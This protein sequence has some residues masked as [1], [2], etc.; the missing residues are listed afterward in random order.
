MLPQ[1]AHQPGPPGRVTVWGRPWHGLV[2][3]GTLTLPN[4]A[5][6]AHPYPGDAGDA[7]VLA[8]RLP[9]TP[10]VVRS[11]EQAAA[12]AAA[13]RQW[14]DYALISGRYDRQL[15]GQRIGGN[16]TWLFA[17]PDGSRWLAT[18][19]GVPD[20]HDLTMPWATHL[21]LDRFGEI[22]GAAEQHTVAVTLT[23]WQQEL[24]GVG[25]TLT[26]AGS[27]TSADV[28]VED[29][30]TGGGR[31]I[32]SI[33]LDTSDA[34]DR[35]PLGFILLSLSGLPGVDATANM[36]VL[37]SRVETLGTITWDE[38][39]TTSDRMK[40]QPGS[41]VTLDEDT[42]GLPTCDGYRLTVTEAAPG[43]FEPTDPFFEP[44]YRE[45]DRSATWAFSDRIIGMAFSATGDPVALLLS[46]QTTMTEYVP[47]P[48][49]FASGGSVSSM[50]EYLGPFQD[51]S[52]CFISPPV[53]TGSLWSVLRRIS[54]YAAT[55]T[56]SLTFGSGDA[57]TIALS[58]TRHQEE[59]FHYGPDAPSHDDTR[60]DTFSL[61]GTAHAVTGLGVTGLVAEGPLLGFVAYSEPADAFAADMKA[62]PGVGCD[63]TGFWNAVVVRYSAT[64]AELATYHT[65]GDGWQ[66]W[67]GV[68]PQRTD[69]APS[70]GH[71]P[72]GSAHPV[73]GDLARAR[74]APV[75]WV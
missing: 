67:G 21:T 53:T 11:P 33:A 44:A 38:A 24:P 62:S 16:G 41:V 12:D 37:K 36:S 72:Y 55:S 43:T 1:D 39:G 6:M 22:G 61:Q 10:A 18:L 26:Y 31:V 66:Y 42:G 32:L 50:R 17:A 75:C 54:T 28:A 34:I 5:T 20:T 25:Y 15:Y 46:A 49:Y 71:K 73:T 56:M 51:G 35:R 63:Q 29:V 52:G 4:G 47:L 8:F 68:S 27:V 7:D 70:S 9:G 69:T 64:A 74:A 57:V 13:G 45:I 19:A 65:G 59:Y 48:G 2:E 40:Y 14:L 60:S 58:Y 30:D 3:G 23:D